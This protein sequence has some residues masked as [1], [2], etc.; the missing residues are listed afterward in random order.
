MWVLLE[1]DCGERTASRPSLDSS[2][3]SRSTKRRPLERRRRCSA[4]FGGDP[5]NPSGEP[6][7][8]TESR[9][10]G[11]D[12]E[13]CLLE[14]HRGFFRVARQSK[15]QVVDHLLV[16]END[17][18]LA[19]ASP[20]RAARTI[21]DSSDGESAPGPTLRVRSGRT[22]LQDRLQEHGFRSRALDERSLVEDCSRHPHDLVPLHE[23][24]ILGRPSVTLRSRSPSRDWISFRSFSFRS[25]TNSFPRI[26]RRSLFRASGHH[27]RASPYRSNEGC[28]RHPAGSTE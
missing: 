7:S 15:S 9:Q 19:R 14:N 2:A 12:L 27:G 23:M 25:T 6:R 8:R 1:G 20:S 4:S 21:S 3:S 17:L 18:L 13:E 26:E 16:P 5:V 22:G 11:E 10:R 28:G 24:G